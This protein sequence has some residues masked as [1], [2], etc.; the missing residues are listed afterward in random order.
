MLH[1]PGWTRA[2]RHAASEPPCMGQ[3]AALC[4]VRAA[5][6]ACGGIRHGNGTA[7]GDHVQRS[8]YCKTCTTAA[9][10]S[11][12]AEFS[13]ESDG[14]TKQVGTGSGLQLVNAGPLHVSSHPAASRA[15]LLCERENA[16]LQR[17]AALRVI[18]PGP[19]LNASPGKMP[20][21]S[22][23]HLNQLHGLGSPNSM[24]WRGTW[25]ILGSPTCFAEVRL[26]DSTPTKNGLVD[27]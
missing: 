17:G 13:K 15:R 2:A 1:Y 21:S 4:Q 14:T 10:P 26:L 3:L 19:M 20:S 22:M 24:A 27:L 12:R 7:V 6:P 23:A 16:E 25:G 18:S 5:Q 8:P 9:G 11:S